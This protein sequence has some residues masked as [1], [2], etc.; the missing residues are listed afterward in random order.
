MRLRAEQNP[1]RTEDDWAALRRIPITEAEWNAAVR[2]AT[3]VNV[4]AW[5]GRAAMSPQ[6]RAE[7]D[8]QARTVV[9]RFLRDNRE[10][11]RQSEETLKIQL[12]REEIRNQELML[13][14]LRLA[15]EAREAAAKAAVSSGNSQHPPVGEHRTATESVPWRHPTEDDRIACI[16]ASAARSRDRK[17]S[18]RQLRRDVLT[19]CTQNQVI[20]DA[21]EN[22]EAALEDRLPRLKRGHGGH[23]HPKD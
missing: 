3:D 15:R 23:G 14:E 11:L 8:Q 18:G 4:A 2:V 21:R 10:R 7:M 20:P 1:P 6:A 12:Q 19:W 17:T 13:E 22:W 9:E 5:R 16:Q